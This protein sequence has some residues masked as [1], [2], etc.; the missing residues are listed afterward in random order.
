MKNE[1]KLA[2]GPVLR[3]LGGMNVTVA[4]CVTFE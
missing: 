1:W 3:G 2:G 4:R